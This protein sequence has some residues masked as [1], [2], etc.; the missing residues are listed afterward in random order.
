MHQVDAIDITVN[1]PISTATGICHPTTNFAETS[2]AAIWLYISPIRSFLPLLASVFNPN[3]VTDTLLGTLGF[4]VY[5][6]HVYSSRFLVSPHPRS[7]PRLSAE[8]V[9]SEKRYQRHIAGSY[10][11]LRTMCSSGCNCITVGRA[12]HS[13]CTA[14]SKT[15]HSRKIVRGQSVLQST[16]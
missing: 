2:N 12:T 14:L 7:H 4:E 10:Q 13:G 6:H 15:T 11:R 5:P 8:S 1:K 3:L 16:P 9:A